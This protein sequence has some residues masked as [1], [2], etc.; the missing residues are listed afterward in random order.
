MRKSISGVLGGIALVAVAVVVLYWNEGRAVETARGLVEGETSVVRLDEIGEV[1]Q[2]TDGALV[3]LTG[4]AESG[5][6]LRDDAFDLEVPALKLHRGVEMLQWRENR[7][8]K[9]RTK[10]GGD[11]ETETVYSYEKIWSD[12]LIDSSGFDEGGYQNPESKPLESLEVTAEEIRVGAYRLGPGLVERINRFEEV[13]PPDELPEGHVAQGNVIFRSADPNAPQVGDL[14]ITLR[15]AMPTDVSVVARNKG[16]RLEAFQTTTGTTI[17]LL[18]YGELD[19]SEMFQ[20]AKS[21]N[22]TLTMGLRI[23]GVLLVFVGVQSV[24]GPVVVVAGVLPLVGRV[25]RAG[26]T[27]ISGIIAVPLA[28]VT[29]SIAWLSYRPWIGAGVLLLGAVVGSGLVWF[30]RKR[31]VAEG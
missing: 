3:H 13:P 21:A 17:K 26:T 19:A 7:E 27:L 29:I 15:A 30:A 6:V 18:E 1:D 16:G 2:G 14:R 20:T 10:I 9:T 25:T 31:A 5:E 23:L 24:L 28:F 12:S 22:K 11:T 4:K 8:T